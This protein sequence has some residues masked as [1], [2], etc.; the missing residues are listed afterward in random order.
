MSDNPIFDFMLRQP[1]MAITVEN[2]VSLNWLGEKT[3]ADLEG[4]DWCEVWDFQAK[5]RGLAGEEEQ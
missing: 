3:L 5:P 2:F 4:E 1:D